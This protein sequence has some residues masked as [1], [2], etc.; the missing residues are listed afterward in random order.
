[1]LFEDFLLE[2]ELKTILTYTAVVCMLRLIGVSRQSEEELLKT[3][4]HILSETS[5]TE[6]KRKSKK[7]FLR[8]LEKI[9]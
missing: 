1:M 7:E 6:I 3:I 4:S 5:G 8:Y 9:D 2:S